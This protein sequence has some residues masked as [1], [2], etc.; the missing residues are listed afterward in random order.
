MKLI[1]RSIFMLALLAVSLTVHSYM[2]GKPADPITSATKSAHQQ[3]VALKKAQSKQEKAARKLMRQVKKALPDASCSRKGT[4][5]KCK[6]QAA[7]RVCAAEV[8]S[9]VPRFACRKD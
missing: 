9:E 2:A 1:R 4:N 7:G 5:V 6:G 8:K 3:T